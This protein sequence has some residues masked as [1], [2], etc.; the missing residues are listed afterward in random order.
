MAYA[1]AAIA[2]TALEFTQ[3]QP[4][5]RA[6]PGLFARL[7][8]AMQAARMRQAEREV[9]RYLSDTG[10]KFTDEAEREIERRFL[11]SPSRW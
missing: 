3:S 6:N 1:P 8:L 5:V 4:Q 9:A 11:S 10:G 7:F 2:P